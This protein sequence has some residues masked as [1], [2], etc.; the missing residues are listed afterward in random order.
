MK[1]EGTKFDDDKIMF[2][3]IDP[4]FLSEM[5]MGLQEGFI[6]YGYK[7]Y[8][9]DLDKNRV[10]SALYRHLV[11]YQMGEFNDKESLQGQSVSHLAKVAVNAMMLYEMELNK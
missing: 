5:A 9:N 3:L 1:K 7:N 4:N 2:S 8:L 11:A 10:I 6:K